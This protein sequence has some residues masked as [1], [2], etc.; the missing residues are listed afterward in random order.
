L[1]GQ[2]RALGARHVFTKPLDVERL[3]STVRRTAIARRLA[4]A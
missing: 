3:L 2:A 4:A 1:L